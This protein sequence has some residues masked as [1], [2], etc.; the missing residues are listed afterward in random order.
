MTATV[1]KR[2][3]N[4]TPTQSVILPYT[5]SR[6]QTA[7]ERYERTGRECYEWQKKLLKPMMATDDECLWVHQ[8]FGFQFLEETVRQK[9]SILSN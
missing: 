3:G 7:I 1:K 6:Y 4:Q 8:K 5:E 2:L 9:L